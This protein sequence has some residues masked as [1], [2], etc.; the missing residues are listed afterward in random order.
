MGTKRREVT[1]LK[2]PSSTRQKNGVFRYRTILTPELTDVSYKYDND[3]LVEKE[4][5]KSQKGAKNYI[6]NDLG[7]N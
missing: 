1:N 4:R 5:T 6:C 2:W 3:E 7:G